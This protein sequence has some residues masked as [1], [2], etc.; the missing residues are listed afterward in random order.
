MAT[1]AEPDT[2]AIGN[3]R[4][5]GGESPSTGEDA[6]VA[7]AAERLE[8][9]TA[10]RVHA[11]LLASLRLRQIGMG[12]EGLELAWDA[13]EGIRAVQ[14]F[15]AAA[16]K[17]L[18]ANASFL[19]SPQMLALRQEQRRGAFGRGIGWTAL[20][21][22]ILLPVLLLLVFFWQADNIARAVAERISIEQESKLGEQAFTAMRGSL[23]LQEAG[24][25]HQTVQT[26]GQRLTGESAY[27][28]RFYV[29][30]D[31]QV[32]AFALPGGIIVVHSGLIEATR[33]PEE[34][35]G[36]LAHEVQH[37]EQRHSLQALVKDLGLRGLW[38]LVTG[39]LGSG[40]LGEVALQLSSLRF[41]LGAEE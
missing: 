36:V 16:L 4:L 18:R 32:N 39:D 12:R 28:Y 6:Q 8:V 3:A 24:P 30:K 5:F 19:A 17:V 22:F 41:S 7:I 10:Q 38:M 11:P 33:R 15:D 21:L 26:I 37:V 27:R 13:Q 23:S 31:P 40:A 29:A 1:T 9:R 34:L 35:A 2:L 14:I 25:A 20:A